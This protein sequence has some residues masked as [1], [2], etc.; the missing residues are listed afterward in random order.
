MTRDVTADFSQR[1][2]T[3]ITSLL[4]NGWFRIFSKA[5]VRLPS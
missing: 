3:N 4:H 2:V 5:K 1:P